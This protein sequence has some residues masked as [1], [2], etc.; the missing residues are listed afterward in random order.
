MYRAVALAGLRCGLDWDRPE[1]LARVAMKLKIQLAGDRVLLDG[2][3]VTETVRTSKVTAVTRHAADNPQVRQ[4][5]A[6]L[7][8]AAA[9]GEDVVTEGRDQGSVVFP[10]AE[11]K[12]FLTASPHERARRRLGDL[13]GQ[14]EAK[15]LG[16]VLDDLNRRDREDAG[17]PVGPLVRPADA[18]EVDTDGMS[19]EQVV[20]RLE[21][22]VRKRRANSEPGSP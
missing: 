18:V 15:P 21:S 2:E 13:E 1:D 17:R 14:G 19:I 7:Q 10:H 8:R 6:G 4:H 9:A 3:D 20:D 12:I 11:C 16:E 22:V 5:L